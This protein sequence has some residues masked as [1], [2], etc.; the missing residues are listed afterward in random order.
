VLGASV[1]DIISILSKE[2]VMLIIIAFVIATP[3][4]WWAA[5]QWLQD[6]AYRT[7]MSWW[8]FAVCGLAMLFIA[9]LTLSIQTIRAA[10]SNP[11]NAL[12]SE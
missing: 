1:T 5:H 6:F 2:F 10:I 12:R 7:T 4:A 3:V 9:F 11:V 8:V